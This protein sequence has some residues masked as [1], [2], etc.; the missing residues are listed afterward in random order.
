MREAISFM[1]MIDW[2]NKNNRN[3]KYETMHDYDDMFH[4]IIIT[5]LSR[6]I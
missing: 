6:K 5:V 1:Q 3:G 4:L 2:D